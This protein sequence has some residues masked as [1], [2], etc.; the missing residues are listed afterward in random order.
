MSTQNT[1][2]YLAW[3]DS[4]SRRWF[5][6]GRLRQIQQSLYEFV[7]TR[8]YEEATRVARMQPI[9]GFANKDQRYL[10]DKLFPLFQNRLMSPNREEYAAHIK[11]LGLSYDPRSPAEPLQVLARSGGHRAT[12]SFA[13]VA[14][15]WKQ[16]S[17]EGGYC[18]VL[19]FFVHG[20]RYVPLDS[21]VRASQCHPA[22]RLLL[23][24]DW[25]NEYDPKSVM[26][27]TGND[28]HLLGWLPRYY[29]TD[30][31]TLR[32]QGLPIE[33]RV[34]QANPLSS[35]LDQRLLCRLTSPWPKEFRA[36]TDPEY[37]PLLDT[38]QEDSL[39]GAASA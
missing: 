26:I 23:L 29:S 10:S 32:E 5:V 21:Q 4:Q 3:Q 8:G 30:I 25:Q 14:A 28:N 19:D 34:E 13:V 37:Q 20:T 27:R 39:S 36:L 24:S 1:T 18:Y 12:D 31:A 7:Y 22:E 35:P 6:V 15:P 9:L 11:R 38:E 2:V 17:K 16:S 33:V